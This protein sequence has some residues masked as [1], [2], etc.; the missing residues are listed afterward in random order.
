[1]KEPTISQPIYKSFLVGAIEF[2]AEYGPPY[3]PAKVTDSNWGSSSGS[4]YNY[5]EFL[6]DKE[7]S[8]RNVINKYKVCH[9][10]DIFL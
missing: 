10:D 6:G 7:G 1:M 4:G 5:W 8:H 9:I 3:S 2:F